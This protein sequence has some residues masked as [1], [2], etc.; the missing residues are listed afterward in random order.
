MSEVASA[1]RGFYNFNPTTAVPPKVKLSQWLFLLLRSF[2]TF[3]SMAKWALYGYR[4]GEGWG[5]MPARPWGLAQGKW[6]YFLTNSQLRFASVLLDVVIYSYCSIWPHLMLSLFLCSSRC[7]T[8]NEDPWRATCP[9]PHLSS[10]LWATAT[11]QWRFC[12]PE[13]APFWVF[14]VNPYPMNG[15]H[16]GSILYNWIS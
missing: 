9:L 16:N 12:V 5:T 15:F 7:S 6:V 10:C 1:L 14:I 13:D 11:H 8:Q 4:Q 2:Q 3:P